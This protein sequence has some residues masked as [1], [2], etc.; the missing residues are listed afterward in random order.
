MSRQV[1]PDSIVGV[2]AGI[3]QRTLVDEL[4]MIRTQMGMQNR[5]E[6]GRSEWDA[7]YDTTP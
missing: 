7:L 3:F 5:T 4:G 2:S 6:N 1:S